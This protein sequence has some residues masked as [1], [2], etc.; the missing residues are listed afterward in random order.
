[1]KMY[2]KNYPQVYLRECKYEIKTKKMV[3]FIDPESNLN[4]FDYSS[5][6]E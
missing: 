3:K 5:V 6:S 1:M 2:K 4:D